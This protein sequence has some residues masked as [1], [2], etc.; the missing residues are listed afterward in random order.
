MIFEQGW[1]Q[2][3]FFYFNGEAKENPIVSVFNVDK[4]IPYVM[5]VGKNKKIAYSGNSEEVDLEKTINDLID[6]K[7]MNLY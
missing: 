1:N 7:N 4:S 3:E 2:M 5:V 6:N